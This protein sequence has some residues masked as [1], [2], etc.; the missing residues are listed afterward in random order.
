V[1]KLDK[2]TRGYNQ[3]VLGKGD[4]ILDAWGRQKVVH[5]HS[6]EFSEEI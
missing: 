2:T 1:I 4:I 6:I 3:N 5:D